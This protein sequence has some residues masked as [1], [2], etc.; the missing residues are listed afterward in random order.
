M[1]EGK[2]WRVG[3]YPLV[4]KCTPT[5]VEPEEK[6]ATYKPIM[7]GWLRGCVSW[8]VLVV[9]GT[10]NQPKLEWVGGQQEG[11]CPRPQHHRYPSGTSFAV[12][13]REEWF[14]EGWTG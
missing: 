2:S 5:R 4:G 1:S 6:A 11:C 13:A 12:G 10:V 8:G 14:V 9:S 7:I 3:P